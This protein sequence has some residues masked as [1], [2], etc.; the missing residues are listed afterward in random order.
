MAELEDFVW[1]DFG[2]YFESINGQTERRPKQKL[3]DGSRYEGE[4]LIGTDVRQGKGIMVLP[5]GMIHEG[6]YVN[7]EAT[8]KGRLINAQGDVYVGQVK[9]YH[10]HGYGKCILPYLENYLNLLLIQVSKLL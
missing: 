5:D 3:Q 4:W 10:A 1:D 8:G 2:G 6:Y 9:G 7:N